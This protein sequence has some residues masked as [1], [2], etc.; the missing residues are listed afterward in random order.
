MVKTMSEE[1]VRKPYKVVESRYDGFDAI[2]LV[3]EPFAGI[4]IK[5]GKVSFNADED[6]D[7]LTLNFEYDIIDKAKKEFGSLQP[8]EKYLGELLEQLIAE[9][10][11][12]N[13]LTYMG[14]VDENRTGDLIEPDS[15]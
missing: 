4:V 6:S 11:Q 15:Q 12:E 9:G 5:Y 13:N 14:G 3:E 8:F 2:Q 7:T 1:K 10:I